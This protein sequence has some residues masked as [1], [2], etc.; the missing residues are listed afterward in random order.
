[1]KLYLVK[2]KVSD[3]YNWDY[4][5]SF[6]VCCNNKDEAKQYHP[7][8]FILYPEDAFLLNDWPENFEEIDVKYL[9]EADQ[10]LP[11]GIVCSSFIAG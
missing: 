5:D 1:M 6:V 10:D 8:G 4:Y 7:S 2:N 3:N 11:A 9:G